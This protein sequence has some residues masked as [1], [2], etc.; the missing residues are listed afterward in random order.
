MTAIS[1]MA[2]A[3]PDDA[4]S[5]S[6]QP[7]LRSAHLLTEFALCGPEVRYPDR[8]QTVREL[9]RPVPRRTLTCG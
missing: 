1:P 2:F 9:G 8:H 5:G 6:V 4:P 7:T 3:L